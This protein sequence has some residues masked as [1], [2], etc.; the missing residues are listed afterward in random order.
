MRISLVLFLSATTFFGVGCGGLVQTNIAE[1]GP[2]GLDAET[3]LV[4]GSATAQHAGRYHENVQ[5]FYRSSGDQKNPSG[6]L[7]SGTSYR[8][9]TPYIS[10]CEEDGIGE[11]C[12]RL[13]AVHLP[14]GQFE[15][16]RIRIGDIFQ[17]ILPVEFFVTPGEATYVGN[18][19]AAFCVGQP[20]QSR[21]AIL[22]ANISVRDDYVRDAGLLRE[23][24]SALQTIPI[25]KRLLPDASW[26]VRVS[27]EPFD[28]GTCAAV[29][30]SSVAV[31]E[32][33]AW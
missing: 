22:G 33:P 15:I 21:G 12:G 8:Y 31:V 17:N 2:V 7:T 26:R 32:Q 6:V 10:S 24:F 19:H 16:F 29:P 28:W 27:Y 20:R 13:F 25:Y 5:F 23:K 1:D 30:Q 18:L 14:A 9:L 4:V 11:H 3:G